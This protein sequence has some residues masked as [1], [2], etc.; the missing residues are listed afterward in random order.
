MSIVK[1]PPF[2]KSIQCPTHNDIYLFIGSKSWER[3]KKSSVMRRGRT[4]CLPPGTLPA[5]YLWPV[6]DCEIIIIDTGMI[7]DDLLLD[8]IAILFASNAVI[9]RYIDKDNHL[10]IFKKDLSN[11]R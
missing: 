7:Q 4:L 10:I 11:E 3:A 9:V 5:S 2:G 8:L 6:S 1:L